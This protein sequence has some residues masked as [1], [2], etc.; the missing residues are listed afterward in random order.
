ML[1]AKRTLVLSRARRTG[2]QDW[3]TG[4]REIKR[5]W[6][7]AF[8]FAWRNLKLKYKQAALGIAWAVIQ[9]L[10]MT[11]AFSLFT[12]RLG[13]PLAGEVPYRAFAMSSLIGWVFFQTVVSLG[14]QGP[15]IDGGLMQRVYFPREFTVLGWSMAALVDLAIITA[16]FFV[17]TPLL[18]ISLHWTVVF[19]IPLSLI[20]LVLG[21][22]LAFALGAIM[23]YYRDVRYALPL[24]MQFL[25]FVSPVAYPLKSIGE[26]WKVL[27]VAVN[28]MAGVLDSFYRVLAAGTTPD[29]LLASIAAIEA[30]GVFI[31]G[32]FIF[33]TLEPFFADVM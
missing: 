2:F 11:L 5:Y 31:I 20:V 17:A 18:G 16:L 3:A 19:I 9:P 27:Y 14:S 7:L 4:L 29:P 32:Y 22:G 10:I 21:T 24:F 15:L 8:V 28:P 1:N 26:D 6:P 13:E 25:L 12:S 33:K 30:V 23:V